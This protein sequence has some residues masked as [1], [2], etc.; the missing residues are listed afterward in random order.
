M[1]A[2]T[3]VAIIALIISLVSLALT[4]LNQ[5]RVRL[6]TIIDGLRGDRRS[7]T[8]SALQIRLAGLL[9]QDQFRKSIIAS[10]LLSWNFETSDRARAAVIAALINAKKMYGNDFE[11]SVSDLK[12]MFSNYEQ[13]V[14]AGDISRGKGRLDDVLNSIK[15]AEATISVS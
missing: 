14:E 13:I 7:V 12:D 8:F 5:S 15:K 2:K 6:E 11:D 10:L 1:D 9:K 4:L 3:I